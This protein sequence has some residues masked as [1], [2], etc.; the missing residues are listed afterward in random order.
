V[1]CDPPHPDPMPQLAPRP[2]SAE[3]PIEP[4]AAGGGTG[5]VG[6]TARLLAWP[7]WAKP[8]LMAVGGLVAV[9]GLTHLIQPG[10]GLVLGLGAL[11]GGWW[12][13]GPGAAPGA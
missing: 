3:D 5:L 2:T 9:D 10:S 13:V 12:M 7:Q 8:A 11:A 1:V 4:T 6:K